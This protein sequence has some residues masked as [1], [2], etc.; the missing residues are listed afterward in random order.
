MAT[1][2]ESMLARMAEEVTPPVVDV[3]EYDDVREALTCPHLSANVGGARQEAFL[4]GTVQRLDGPV[5][6]QRRRTYGLLLKRGGHEIYRQTWLFPTVDAA[7]AQLLSNP[8]GDGLVRA[9]LTPWLRRMQTQFAAALVGLDRGTTPEGADELIGLVATMFDGRPT[10][11]QMAAGFDTGSDTLKASVAARD[12]I[13]ERFYRDALARREDLAA[14]CA[15]GEVSE[16]E[17]PRDLLM[18]I[19]QRVDPAF[20]D[21]ELAKREA[22]FLLSGGI[23][24]TSTSLM[25]ALREL[26][27]WLEEHPEQEHRLTDPEFLLAAARET[28]RLHP[29]APG[30]PRLATHD[31]TLRSGLRIPEGHVAMMKPVPAGSEPSVYGEDADRFNPDRNV[32]PGAYPFGFAFAMGPHMCFGQPLVMGKTGL[33]GSLVYQLKAMFDAGVRPDPEHPLPHVDGLRYAFGGTRGFHE[34]T[35]HPPAFHVLF[36]RARPRSRVSAG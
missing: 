6:V 15:A 8:D 35:S 18:L 9:N 3:V 26:F 13:I 19:A 28:L 34:D 5:H 14:R 33:D 24:T 32:A 2:T 21:P 27:A 23:H 7:M 1:D 20:D 12:E 30:Y 25:W 29:I 11:Y 4:T 36:T 10:A 17:L 31:V 22:I 16:D